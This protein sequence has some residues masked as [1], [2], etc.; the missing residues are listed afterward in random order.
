MTHPYPSV[1]RALHRVE[2]HYD[3]TPP[4]TGPRPLMPF[5]RQLAE[6]AQAA[7]LRV[8]P[9]AAS[10]RAAFQPRPA[11]RGESTG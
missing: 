10:L 4:Y 11:G 5:E 3:E 6:G 9:I 7:L 8:A 1:D 2:R